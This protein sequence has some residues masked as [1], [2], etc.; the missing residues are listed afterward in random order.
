M[1]EP[2]RIG[3]LGTGT[4][5]TA[6]ARML[7]NDG[8][9]VTCWSAIP[10][11][12]ELLSGKR[13]HPNLP[14]IMV[15]ESIRFTGEIGSACTEKDLVVFAVPS[16]YVRRTAQA[17][18]PYLADGQMIVDVAKGIEPDTLKTMT[19]IISDVLQKENPRIRVHL[20]ALS[21]PTHAEEVAADMPTTIVAASREKEVAAF[22]QQ[23]FSN[24]VMRVYT[25]EDIKGVE[26][27]GAL[28]NVMALAAGIAS[29][30]GYGDNLRAAIIT[31][32]SA[33]MSRL[34]RA[35]GCREQTF[36]GLAGIGDLIVTATS[37]HSRNNRAGYLIGQGK[38]AQE[39][40]REVGMVVEGINALPAARKLAEKYHV[41]MPITEAVHQVVAEGM[42]PEEMLHHLM[43]RAFTEEHY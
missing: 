11:E 26:I 37:R 10:E 33:E 41:E 13:I 18:V 21:G 27:C 7:A 20:C 43:E 12:I 19:E 34:G 6:L 4:W 29:G 1:S 24:H 40:I 8:H 42:K 23:V 35:M 3:I 16:V 36:A 22:V 14:G 17:A 28:K 15:P 31:R 38:T 5:G 39:A 2:K 32:G 9:E 30:M 25:N